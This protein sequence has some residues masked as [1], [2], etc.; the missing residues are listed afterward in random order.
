MATAVETKVTRTLEP[1]QRVVLRG[2]GWAG[3]EALLNLRGEGHVRIA[4][5]GEDAALGVPEV[6]RFDG[7]VLVIE[8]LQADGTY[9]PV[10]VSPSLPMFPPE[11]VV[12]WVHRAEGVSQ[13]QW[14]REFREWVRA[15]LAP[16]HP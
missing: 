7:E 9:T 10:P 5:D 8:Q 13:T 14:M 16:R 1:E 6:W 2:V 3:Y 12:R 15:E 4:C 11:E